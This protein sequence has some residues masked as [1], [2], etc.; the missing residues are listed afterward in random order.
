MKNSPFLAPTIPVTFQ[1]N[2]VEN[3]EV[4]FGN[5]DPAGESSKTDVS[6]VAECLTNGLPSEAPDI[7]V[8]TLEAGIL[9]K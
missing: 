5:T 7:I 4:I 8:N 9:K 3:R 2:A 1:V 6:V